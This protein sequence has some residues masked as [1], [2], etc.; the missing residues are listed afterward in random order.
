MNQLIIFLFS[1]IL[2]GQITQKQNSQDFVKSS[3]ANNPKPDRLV[4]WPKQ[5]KS[6]YLGTQIGNK[7]GISKSLKDNIKKFGLI[8]LLTPSGIHLS[9]ILLFV[10]I[11]IKRKLGILIYLPLLIIFST[12]SGFYSRF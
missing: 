9:S 5:E 6:F 10:F 12:L 1:I 11:F 2:I 4:N 7:D 3:K 8:H